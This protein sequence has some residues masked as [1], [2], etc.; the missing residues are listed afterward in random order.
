LR[1]SLFRDAGVI[2]QCM[3]GYPISDTV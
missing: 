2:E 1:L 3:E